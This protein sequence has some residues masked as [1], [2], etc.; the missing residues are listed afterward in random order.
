[1]PTEE[2]EWL[3]IADTFE[4]KWN[5]SH[6]AGAFSAR[7]IAI[8]EPLN[9]GTI[10]LN[11]KGFHSILLIAVVNANYEFMYFDVGMNGGCDKYYMYTATSFFEV[12]IDDNMNLPKDSLLPGTDVSV[13]YVFVAD[14]DYVIENIMRPYSLENITYEEK[15][16]NY[17]FSRA[18]RVADNAFGVLFERFGVL[19]KNIYI[20]E[21]DLNSVGVAC[22]A[23][24][25]YLA[26]TNEEYIPR[27]SLDIEDE[28]NQRFQTASWRLKREEGVDWEDTHPLLSVPKG[29]EEF[30]D[31]KGKLVR[32]KFM[33]YFNNENKLP[34][35]EQ[36][37]NVVPELKFVY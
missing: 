8:D 29:L 22:C 11:H 28:V 33:K 18:K 24:H 34:F 9:N 17:R 12:M 15:I 5:F 27:E 21:R 2:K 3:D 30:P 1:M 32:E 36:M 10:F 31:T 20:N 6:C 14:T 25:N 19:H 23:L 35:Q 7:H 16:F 4:R 26:K 37:A 13:P